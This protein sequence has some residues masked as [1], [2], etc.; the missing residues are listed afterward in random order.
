[1]TCSSSVNGGTGSRPMRR[2]TA[3]SFGNSTRY[4]SFTPPLVR[5]RI[6]S[7]SR[8]QTDRTTESMIGRG[9]VAITQASRA[10]TEEAPESDAG[11]LAMVRACDPLGA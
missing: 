11:V 7:T 4:V 1:M 8:P 3:A 5:R 2:T 6:R 9:V 10:T